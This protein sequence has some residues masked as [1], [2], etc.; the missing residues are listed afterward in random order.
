MCTIGRK[1]VVKNKG[2]KFTCKTRGFRN[3]IISFI[4]LSFS[5][6][7]MTHLHSKRFRNWCK[8]VHKFYLIRFFILRW[9]NYAK[10]SI[11]PVTKHHDFP[12]GSIF[13]LNTCKLVAWN[14][15][16]HQQIITLILKQF[17][18]NYMFHNF[19]SITYILLETLILVTK[20][21]KKPFKYALY[22]LTNH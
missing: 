10:I 16:Y 6:A 18:N 19:F 5:L 7:Q 12:T 1:C 11:L 15:T 21:K 9:K 17:K 3:I 22:I 8:D 20:S 4:A 14:Q 2:G 13:I